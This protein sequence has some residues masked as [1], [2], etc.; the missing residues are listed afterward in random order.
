MPLISTD[1]PVDDL[2]TNHNEKRYI[3]T[4]EGVQLKSELVPT[5]DVNEE[6][7]VFQVKV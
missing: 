3:H 6:S 1:M 5:L 7:Q 4:N 2:H